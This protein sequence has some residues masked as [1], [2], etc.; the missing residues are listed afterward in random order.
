[1]ER[2]KQY[3]QRGVVSDLMTAL[4]DTESGR[5]TE[6]AFKFRA[7][8]LCILAVRK[9][10]GGGS[11]QTI[12]PERAHT[13]LLSLAHRRGGNLTLRSQPSPSNLGQSK[14]LHPATSVTAAQLPST[15]YHAGAGAPQFSLLELLKL[16]GC[17]LLL[18][19]EQ[20]SGLK[21]RDSEQAS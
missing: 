20:H 14:S 16:Q 18:T 19:K 1:M 4:K 13:L 5:G 12:G 7:P 11:C 17:Q 15:L 10:R 21:S 2:R 9:G 6:S 8:L 3:R